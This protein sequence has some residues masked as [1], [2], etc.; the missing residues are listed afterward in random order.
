MIIKAPGIYPLPADQ[1]HADPVEKPSLSCSIAKVLLDQSAHHAWLAH[2]RLNPKFEREGDSRS[3][4]GSAAHS[5]LLEDRPDHVVV[6]DA[7]DWRTKAAK[8]ARDAAQAAG[9]FAILA[10]KFADVMRMV[11]AAKDFIVDTELSGIFENGLT[12]QTVVWQDSSY[13]DTPGVWC[14]ARPDKMTVDKKIIMDYKTTGSAAPDEVAKQIGRMQYDLQSEFY[15]RGV[16]AVAG[17]DPIFVF[18][19]QEI[20]PPY[21]CSLISLSNAYREVGRLKVKRAMSLWERAV[22]TGNW[23][24]YSNKILYAEPKPWD[25]QRAEELGDSE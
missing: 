25:L 5:I 23:L 4:L 7:D 16:H 12:E 22:T 14:R 20:T 11:K 9:K 21:A 2:P 18:L 24:G 1:Y 13:K 10:H 8:E 19:F 6:V 3:D 17:T 15:T